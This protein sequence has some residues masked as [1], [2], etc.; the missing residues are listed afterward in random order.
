MA[1]G[2]ADDLTLTELVL[3]FKNLQ[4]QQSA[5]RFNERN[6][7]DIVSL[8]QA[9]VPLD[10]VMATDGRGYLT[11]AHILSEVICEVDAAGGRIPV[12]ELSSL[13][14]VGA[15]SIERAVHTLTREDSDHSFQVVAGDL[16]SSAYTRCLIKDAQTCLR[17]SGCFALTDIARRYCVPINYVF[18]AVLSAVRDG[19]L[20]AVINDDIVYT[21]AFVAAQRRKLICALAGSLS[22][23]NVQELFARHS[24][25]P[26]LSTPLLASILGKELCGWGHLEGVYY[27][28]MHL[29][30]G[31]IQR[32]QGELQSN[33]FISF[34]SVRA[35]G[36][37]QVPTFLASTFNPPSAE[38][39][40]LDSAEAN[41]R[42]AKKKKLVTKR[43]GVPDTSPTFSMSSEASPEFPLAGHVL[44]GCFILDRFFSDGSIVDRLDMV[45][46]GD[47]AA[48]SLNSIFPSC[49]SFPEDVE[50][51]LSCLYRHFPVCKSSCTVIDGEGSDSV[52]LVHMD[53]VGALLHS[54][55]DWLLSHR[56]TNRGLAHK[57][58][59]SRLITFLGTGPSSEQA[60]VV[61]SK[62]AIRRRLKDGVG[63]SV[64]PSGDSWL[65]SEDA[66]SL[67]TKIFELRKEDI[68]EILK[69][70][71]QSQRQRAAASLRGTQESLEARCRDRW[72]RL[73]VAS[74]GIAWLA[75]RCSSDA[76][77]SIN[78]HYLD[79]ICVAVVADLM[80]DVGMEQLDSQTWCEDHLVPLINSSSETYPSLS[81]LREGVKLFPR[82][83]RAVF[84][85][86]LNTLDADLVEKGG[87]EG[88]S[89]FMRCLGNACGTGEISQSCFHAQN[90][91]VERESQ[92]QW[93][94]VL[95]GRISRESFVNM[96][97][98]PSQQMGLFMDIVLFALAEKHRCFV[99]APISVLSD[100]VKAIGDADVLSAYSELSSDA[101]SDDGLSVVNL[102]RF[103][104]LKRS[105]VSA[106]EV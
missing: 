1:A 35:E 54:V 17:E 94:S 78:R 49:V 65:S 45:S 22:L 79:S 55:K 67:A 34:T 40:S 59:R 106:N 85:D 47:M 81:T 15:A 71:S 37:S 29:R 57:E 69:E 83:R 87:V 31:R 97:G 102:Q 41:R 42:G 62:G 77:R 26:A 105:V 60:G 52:F 46:R 9:H 74:K 64:L 84:F 50:K 12:V 104:V 18:D 88:L 58:L 99:D 43:P 101:V 86:L 72:T 25:L 14:R 23:T 92:A 32:I 96:T 70:T 68:D 91:K 7:V 8:L 66:G 100:L 95:H 36:V 38:Q 90:R 19:T 44:S 13:I 20:G 30:A 80:A 76:I 51:I 73:C 56:V 82:E 75:G 103:D 48:I 5:Q 63:A 10:L 4:H 53:S 27:I 6:A 3:K 21:T 16:I 98:S 11:Q 39:R 2:R 33:G 89:G 24:I 28:P 93:L 61:E